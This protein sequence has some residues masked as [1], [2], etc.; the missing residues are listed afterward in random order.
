VGERRIQ[1]YKRKQTHLKE[2]FGHQLCQLAVA[3]RIASNHFRF[4]SLLILG[5]EKSNDL[6]P[7]TGKKK[8][9]DFP[10]QHP[11]SWLV[12]VVHHYGTYFFLNKKRTR[13]YYYLCFISLG[14]DLRLVI[15]ID[16]GRLYIVESCGYLWVKS[17]N[18]DER[19]SPF[20]GKRIFGRVS[21]E[22]EN[23]P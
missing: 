12:K 13:Y 2:P 16:C 15:F 8:Y 1:E 22:K 20:R 4:F 23:G 9:A 3:P 18:D 21:V 7:V 14:G 17:P 11:W 5:P 10:S 19:P 6:F